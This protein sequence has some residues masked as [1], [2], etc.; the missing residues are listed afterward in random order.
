[1]DPYKRRP[2][3]LLERKL[4]HTNQY[5]PYFVAPMRYSFSGGFAYVS[6]VVFHLLLDIFKS[7]AW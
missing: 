7:Q 6:S 2:N 4:P 5:A 1:M 3:N